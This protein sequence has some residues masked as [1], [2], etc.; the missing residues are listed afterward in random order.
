MQA[1]I[2]NEAS[3]EARWQ[4]DNPAP[5]FGRPACAALPAG[6]NQNRPVL[7]F[8]CMGMRTFTEVSGDRMLA[9]VPGPLLAEF[10]KKLR[11]MRSTNDAMQSF[12]QGRMRSIAGE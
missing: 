6:I 3:G 1:M 7:S 11:G 10:A 5:V 4:R 8:G 9:I 12:Y 2:W